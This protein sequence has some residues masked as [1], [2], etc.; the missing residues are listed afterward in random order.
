MN[1]SVVRST[2]EPPALDTTARCSSPAVQMPCASRPSASATANAAARA[3]PPCT[4]SSAAVSGVVTLVGGAGW[5]AGKPGKSAGAER[6]ARPRP[7][8]S[9][10]ARTRRGARRSCRWWRP[11]PRGRSPPPR[12]PRSGRPRPSPAWGGWPRSAGTASAPSPRTRARRDSPCGAARAPRRRARQATPTSTFRKRAGALPCDTRTNWPGSPLPHSST[13]TSPHSGAEQIASQPRQKSGRDPGVARVAEQPPALAAAD[14][15]GGL[16]G[17]LEV[18]APVV[19]RPR[20]VGLDQQPVVGVGDQVVERARVAGLEVHVRHPH[21]RLAREA[22]GA[23]APAG[24]LQADLGGRLARGE[25]AGEHAVADDRNGAA[26]H[27][28]VVPPERAEAARAWWRRR[29]RSPAP[30]RTGATR[31]RPAPRSCRPRTR[32]RGR[33]RGRAPRR[34][35][36]TRGSARRAARRPGSASCGRP[37]RPAR[38]AARPPPRR[39]RARA[40][41]APARVKIS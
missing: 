23:R 22:V 21:D 37:G 12:S 28:L 9:P 41:P 11:G 10:A 40:R 14:L 15:P 3:R 29:S 35:R 30:S 4:G 17:E 5:I 1:A 19:D 36:S 25:E 13:E 31:R 39:A 20:A 7:P 6:G 16:A 18:Q 27:A 26:L 38:A 34:G 32:S 33:A 2:V 24:A 8:R